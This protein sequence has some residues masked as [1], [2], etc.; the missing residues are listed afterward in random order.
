MRLLRPRAAA[1]LGCGACAVTRHNVLPASEGTENP[2][3]RRSMVEAHTRDMVHAILRHQ[4]LNI[5][6]L[7]DTIEREVYSFAI[8]VT[9]K[10][11]LKWTSYLYGV[12]FLKVKH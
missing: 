2:L 1:V 12:S 9:Y 4:T 5:A 10:Y 8:G 3:D 11:L 7:P 6:Y